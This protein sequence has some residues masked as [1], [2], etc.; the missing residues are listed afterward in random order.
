MF[1]RDR[2][3][4]T[5]EI[6][7]TLNQPLSG[8]V[9]F[10][11]PAGIAVTPTKLEFQAVAPG[12][13]VR[14]PVAVSTGSRAGPPDADVPGVLDHHRPAADT[15]RAQ[16]LL[17]F[18]GPTLLNEYAN[19]QGNYV[20]YSP[21][22]VA[23]FDMFHGLCRYLADDAGAVR[24]DG[25]PLFTLSDGKTPLLDEETKQA[26]TWPR[27]L[28]P[29]WSRMPTTSAAGRPSSTAAGWRFGW[30]A[31]GR[32]SSVP[33][34]RFPAAGSPPAARRAGSGSWPWTPPE[35][36]AT[37]HRPETRKSRQPNSSSPRTVESGLQ[38]RTAARRAVP[39]SGVAVLDRHAKRRQLA[40]RILPA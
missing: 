28:R 36:N 16:P 4:V 22:F 37:A 8:H 18:A 31:V 20:V 15:H 14:L 24:L 29:T 17:V 39:G 1:A 40:S 2:R 3:E 10:A 27:R 33:S 34:S 19:R 7:N 35:R 21:K 32:S 23:R 26:F 30:T 11:A 5:L 12:A 9:E 6:Q 38:V 13:T 25:A